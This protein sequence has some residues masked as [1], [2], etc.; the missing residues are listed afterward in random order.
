MGC[1]FLN[2]PYLLYYADR[3]HDVIPDGPPEIHLEGFG[4]EDTHSVVNSLCFGQTDGSMPPK[5][6]LFLVLSNDMEQNKSLSNP[7]D[8]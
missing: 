2:P 4:I 7:W 3:N 8:S 6:A 1:G 5:E